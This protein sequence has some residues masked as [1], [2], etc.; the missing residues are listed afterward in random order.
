MGVFVEE[1]DAKLSSFDYSAAARRLRASKAE[2][3]GDCERDK[4]TG[5]G[6]DLDT[7]DTED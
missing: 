7:E 5:M 3:Q 6:F 4:A 2:T 1:A